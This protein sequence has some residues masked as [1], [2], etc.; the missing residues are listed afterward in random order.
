M[1]QNFF[2]KKIIICIP[3]FLGFYLTKNWNYLHIW[4][5][6]LLLIKNLCIPILNLLLHTLDLVYREGHR[7]GILYLPIPITDSDRDFPYLQNRLSAETAISAPIPIR[8]GYRFVHCMP[9]WVGAKIKSHFS[10]VRN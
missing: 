5:I 4:Q 1:Q 2:K 7:Y 9:L 6:T 8:I 3:M 10:L